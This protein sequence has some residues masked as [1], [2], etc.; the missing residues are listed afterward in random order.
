M[1]NRLSF[2]VPVLLLAGAAHVPGLAQAPDRSAPPPVGAPPELRVPPIQPHRLSNGVPVWI[3]EMH[4]VPI[5]QVS[6]LLDFGSAAD[7]RGQ[8]G[9]ASLT[10]AMLDEGAGSRSALELADAV[11][12]LGADLRT[13]STFDATSVDLGV[14]VARLAEALP[15]MAD[16]ALRP[17]FPEED[18]ARLKRE[19]LTALL[20]ARDNPA[21]VASE[22]Y[23]RVLYGTN[24][25]YGTGEIGVP[26]AVERFTAADLRRFYEA[27]YRSDEASL[28]VVGDVT[29]KTVLPLLE[30]AFGGW[31][32]PG[33]PDAVPP[34]PPAS[35]PSSRRVVI[36]DKPGAAQSQ[37][38]IGWIGA[39]RSTPDYFPL[40]VLNTILGGSFTSRLNQN[41]REE[42]GYAYSAGSGFAMRRSAGPFVASAGVQTDKTAEAL[43]EFFEELN[44]ILQPVGD[45]ELDKAKNFLAL[46]LPADFETTGDL[47]ARL[48]ELIVYDLPEDYF[49]RYVERLRAVTAAD[50]QR[51]AK[52]Y[53]Q[54]GRFVVLVVGDWKTIEAPVRGLK[55]GAVST[56]TVE[57]LLGPPPQAPSAEH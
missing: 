19:R 51:V 20:Q 42:H 17:T 28:I 34:L 26:A 50:V 1:R 24:H 23:S 29:A 7:P 38:R 2:L 15:L 21:A 25:R 53:I 41:L 27:R 11:D 49:S 37:I 35:Q 16:V 32:S 8:F 55:L 39:A 22:G 13:R 14:P 3:V 57:E 4:E 40:M 46:G 12:F 52:Q 54:P 45:E 43:A 18:L 56:M 30:S 36:V 33:A 44:G 47:A 9:L 10:A 48:Q 6:L 31:S 5:A